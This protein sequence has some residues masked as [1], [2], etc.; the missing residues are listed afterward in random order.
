MPQNI[1]LLEALLAPRGYELVSASSGE[2]ALALVET[3]EPDLILCDIVMPGI[4]GYEVCRRLRAEPKTRML[5]VVMITASGSEQK[6]KAL[7]AGADDF[8]TK[9]FEKSE[10]LARVAS[11][12]RV[13]EYH[14]VV[15]AQ[16]ATLSE[17]NRTLEARVE[18]QVKEMERLNGLRR[19]LPPQL[20]DAVVSSADESILQDHR[21]EI[22]VVVCALRGFTGFSELA[23]P[24]EVLSILREYHTALGQIIAKFEGTIDRFV[25]DE[26]TVFFNDPLPC[27]DPAGQAMRMALEIRARVELQSRSWRKRGHD[28]DFVAGIA[29]GYATLGQI[30]FEGRYD[31]GAVGP[32]MDL[33]QGLC[34]R[35]QAGELFV[36]QRV[37]AATDRDIEVESLGEIELSGFVKPVAAFRVLGAKAQYRGG[38][39]L[40]PELA[41]VTR[42]EQE[43][44]ALIARGFSNRDIATEL[45][46]TEGTA[47]NH[48]EHILTKL[49]FSSRAQIATWATEYGLY[50]ESAEG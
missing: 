20:V 31:Y 11:L 26:I 28:L 9:P 10:L 42:R 45:V 50:S 39:V 49:G 35:A 48:V 7:E 2:Q 32:V 16:R 29:T 12:L 17:L 13:K 34:E 40:N 6:V 36:A 3:T 46:I 15:E 22:T 33:A 41:R 44:A 25:A 21:R 38:V 27:T 43:V 1:R 19:F 4:D 14:D 30:G 37:Q 24:E 23:E 8:V 47:A 18:Q 5:P